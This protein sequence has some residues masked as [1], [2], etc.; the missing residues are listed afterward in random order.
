MRL[1]RPSERRAQLHRGP[2]RDD[3][4]RRRGNDQPSYSAGIS[5]AQAKAA[6]AYVWKVSQ[7]QI[8]L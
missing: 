2:L 8:Q 1:K 5:D 3:P 6:A 7:E 4:A